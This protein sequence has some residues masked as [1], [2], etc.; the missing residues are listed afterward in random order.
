[1]HEYT[2]LYAWTGQNWSAY[3][4]D[5]PGCA[6]TCITREEIEHNYRDALEA[7]L[8]FA[9]ER[10]EPLPEPV[11]EAGRMAVAA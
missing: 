3:L 6:A 11:T 5:V 8:A 4:P 9:A 7:H 1:M 10:G 2:V